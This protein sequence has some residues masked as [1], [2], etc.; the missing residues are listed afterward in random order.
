MM[1]YIHT[2]LCENILKVSKLLSG[3]YFQIEV[4]I[5]AYFPEKIGS[6]LLISGHRLMTL[7]TGTKFC[8]IS[9]RVSKFLSRHNFQTELFKGE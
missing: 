8:K 2:E 3:H 5:G 7:Y 4:F 6:W 9:Q 1:L